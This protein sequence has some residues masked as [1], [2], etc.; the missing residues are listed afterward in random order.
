MPIIPASFTQTIA[1]TH[2]VNVTRPGVRGAATTII[3]YNRAVQF[4]WPSASTMASQP[5]GVPLKFTMF[6]ELPLVTWVGGIV[7]STQ[8]G[9]TYRLND[10]VEV[11]SV[12]GP[13]WGGFLPSPHKFSVKMAFDNA[14]GGIVVVTLEGTIG[15]QR[16]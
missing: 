11:L 5:I 13:S 3:A 1:P 4:I 9:F 10:D 6:D 12:I 8:E 14:Q 7:N 2:I 15:Y 16:P